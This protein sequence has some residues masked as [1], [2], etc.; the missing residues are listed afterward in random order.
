MGTGGTEGRKEEKESFSG[1]IE[2]QAPATGIVR[3]V[4]PGFPKLRQEV[5]LVRES[6]KGREGLGE[7]G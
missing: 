2:Q 5:D 4:I 3:L 1:G 7:S 6:K